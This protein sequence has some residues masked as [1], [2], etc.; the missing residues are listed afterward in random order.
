METI[1][2]FITNMAWVTLVLSLL[3]IIV[4][5]G[6]TVMYSDMDRLQD[7]IKGYERTWPI[8]KPVLLVILSAV[9]LISV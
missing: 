9:W 4:Q 8:R 7:K 2:K 6:N 1:T 5:V 3:F